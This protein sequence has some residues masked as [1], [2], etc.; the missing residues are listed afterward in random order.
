MAIL[1]NGQVISGGIGV[2]HLKKAE[3]LADKDKY[4]KSGNFVVLDDVAPSVNGGGD[5]SSTT[6]N[7]ANTDFESS[8][9]QGVLEEVDNILGD[10]VY[11]SEIIDETDASPRDADTLGGQYSANDIA[12]IE[13]N[14]SGINSNL[15]KL[16]TIT[17]YSVTDA[18]ETL[19]G[20][21]IAGGHI[22]KCGN[23][24]TLSIM[25]NSMTLPA[26]WSAK[27]IAKITDSNLKPSNNALWYGTC[28]TGSPLRIG[29]HTDGVIH[30]QNLSTATNSGYFGFNITYYTK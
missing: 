10:A 3:Y 29:M 11:A 16:N 2:I 8:D 7:N 21:S 25:F 6:F 5:A 15:D 28:G 19:D 18:L 20:V 12:E 27:D 13:E 26:T 23:S 24:V 30:I 22:T 17:A 1:Q 4:D 9:I 14:I